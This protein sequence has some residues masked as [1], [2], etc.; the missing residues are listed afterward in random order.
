M[1]LDQADP[2]IMDKGCID[3][4]VVHHFAHLIGLVASF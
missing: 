1:A 2:I 4:D 3:V